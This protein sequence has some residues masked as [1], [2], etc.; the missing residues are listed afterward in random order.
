LGGCNHPT[1]CHADS[2]DRQARWGALT[3]QY[4]QTNDARMGP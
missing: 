1:R 2:I 3:P 4:E